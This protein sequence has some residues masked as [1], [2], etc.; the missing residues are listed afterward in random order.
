MK[1]SRLIG[2][3]LLL[4]FL[5]FLSYAQDDQEIA[6]VTRTF[7]L[8]N[9]TIITQPGQ[10]IENGQILIKNGLIEAVGK[11]VSVPS[12]AK[13]I[14]VDSM[15]IYPGFI[16]GLSRTGVPRPKDEERREIKDPGN[17][18]NDAAGIQPERSVVDLLSADDSS[19]ESMRKLG[20]TAAHV[21][22]HGNMLPGQ[23]A[24]ILLGGSS[25][26]EMVLASNTSLF[27][28]LEGARRVYP[29]TT[30]AVMSKWRE[31]YQQAKQAQQHEKNYKNNP[32]GMTRP[33]YDGT[34]EA[35][36]PVLDQELP[37]F[38]TAESVKDAYRVLAL[39]EELGFPLVLAGLKQG[40][41]MTDELKA[42]GFPLLLSLDIPESK[43]EKKKEEGEEEDKEKAKPDPEKE[44]LKKRQ[45]EA[46]AKHQSQAATLS[47]A[48]LTFG[49]STLEVKSGDVKNNLMTMIEKGISEEKVLASLTTIPA[50]MLGMS[51]MLGTLE[52]GKIANLVITDKPYFSKESNVRYVFVDGAPFEYEA[53]KPKKKGDASA[54]VSAAGEWSYTINIP[55]QAMSGTF[56]IKQDGDGQISGTITS[57]DDGSEGELQE[58]VL[59]GN[60]LSFSF[61]Y[62]AGG[63]AM[64]VSFDVIIDGDEVEGTVTAGSFGTFDVEGERIGVPD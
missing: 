43:E 6:P 64:K 29:A 40:F 11:S 52:K 58:V 34:L 26:E 5:P 44:A 59:S 12:N 24:I 33:S 42:K 36:Y 22:P 19:I 50:K 25:P 61:P 47:E 32:R 63:Q 17:P 2:G 9:A 7:V 30:M 27:S 41:Y 55:G 49:F 51:D 37:V 15:Y 48:G 62:D 8:K 35:F 45:K 56:K 57:P 10:M 14:D 23:G 28:Q 46:I 16:E 18:P 1:K 60:N 4:C 38:F 31:L 39:Q 13:V 3:L 54:K 21:V 20:F 53:K